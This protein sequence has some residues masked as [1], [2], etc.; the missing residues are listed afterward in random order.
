MR[1]IIL[2]MVVSALTAAASFG[3]VRAV[4]RGSAAEA[5]LR[6]E[7]RQAMGDTAEQKAE[8]EKA[9]ETGRRLFG[10]DERLTGES[11]G[12]LTGTLVRGPPTDYGIGDWGYTG[13]IFQVLD[14]VSDTEC[15]VLPRYKG[16]E[17][18]LIRGFDMSKVTDG[19]EFILQHPAFIQKTYTYPTV[20]G[21]RK[22]VLVLE[23]NESKV[24][25]V[26]AKARAKRDA[27][28]AAAEAK[29]AAAEAAQKRIEDAKRRTWTSASGAHQTEAKFV[30]MIHGVVT[31][32]KDDGQRVEVPLEQLSKEDQ[33]FIKERKWRDFEFEP[34]P[35]VSDPQSALTGDDKSPAESD[36]AVPQEI[37]NSVGMKLTLIPA[38]EFLMG[39]P[40]GEE[41]R[42][43]EEHQHRVRITKPFYLG[44]YEVTQAEYERVM[45]SNPS[46]FKESGLDAPV[47]RVMWVD[48]YEF[49]R[50]LSAMPEEQQGG[51]VYRLP[52][53]AEW[54]YAC[55]AGTTTAWYYGDD[56]SDL[57]NVAWFDQNSGEQTHPV[58]KKAPNGWGLYDMHGN[59]W[60]WCWDWFE[61]DY[62]ESSPIDDPKGPSEVSFRVMRGGSWLGKLEACRSA[63]RGRYEPSS[64]YFNLG[65]RAAAVLPGRVTQERASK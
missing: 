17:V 5:Q 56:Q 6:A 49:C 57:P 13:L 18:M 27:E 32:E 2:T 41:L 19:V 31:L 39:S 9:L 45:G 54:E 23:R 10:V 38:G 12:E 46:H 29:R 40:E 50:R 26:L 51:R 59:V 36:D 20:S 22:T 11:R 33:D 15:L 60:E 37:V 35:R 16:A 52:T 64:P 24:A 30:N 65:F 63:F 14:K 21:G 3:Q 44:V 42:S 4:Q 55:R 8:R 61:E 25:E 47:E 43:P 1:T 34:L 48:A 53:E 62:Y 7:H 58:G 28:L